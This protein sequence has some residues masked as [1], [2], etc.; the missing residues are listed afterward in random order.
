MSGNHRKYSWT[1]SMGLHSIGSGATLVLGKVLRSP[2][3]FAKSR[4]YFLQYKTLTRGL[5]IHISKVA[6]QIQ[7]KQ[8]LPVHFKGHILLKDPRDSA[9]FALVPFG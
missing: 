5:S 1:G 8:N 4:S 2:L 9:S 6:L 3:Q 7:I